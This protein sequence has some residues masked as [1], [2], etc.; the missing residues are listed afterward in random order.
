[1]TDL[2]DW[3]A[4]R[5]RWMAAR[6]L[7]GLGDPSAPDFGQAGLGRHAPEVRVRVLVLPADPA[8]GQ[9]DFDD[10]TWDWWRQPWPNPFDPDSHP[11]WG[12]EW[13]PTVEAAVRMRRWTEDRTWDDYLALHRNGALEAGLGRLGST[14][15]TPRPDAQATTVFFLT[16]IVGRVW[17]SLDRYADVI[18]QRGIPGP[19]QVSLGFRGTQDAV[20]GN[21]A[22]GWVEPDHAWPEEPPKCRESNLLIMKELEQWPDDVGGLALA[23]GGRIED[24]WGN[25]QRRF[26]TRALEGSGQFD[27]AKV[28]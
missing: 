15:F 26:I 18:A 23:I 4:L 16:T 10:D 11:D 17:W 1:V 9:I 21:V 6:T 19:W 25:A 2:H 3:D 20:L 27:V 5:A 22:D 8:Q 28:R 12:A 14:T 7:L 24:A 13:M